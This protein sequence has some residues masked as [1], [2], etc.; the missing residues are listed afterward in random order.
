MRVGG[1]FPSN[2]RFPDVVLQFSISSDKAESTSRPKQTRERDRIAN[3]QEKE[4]IDAKGEML[5][6]ERYQFTETSFGYL[7][8]SIIMGTDMLDVLDRRR[9]AAQ[10]VFVNR[11]AAAYHL[12]NP[13]LRS[14]GSNPCDATVLSALCY[15]A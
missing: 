2:L 10:A 9:R 15:P 3:Q 11:K 1:R 4:T 13:D 7:G 12:K 6:L 14:R 8:R 5:H